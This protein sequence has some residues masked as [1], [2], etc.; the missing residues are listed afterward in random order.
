MTDI[1][2]FWD[3]A[4]R[5]DKELWLTGSNLYYVWTP[6][7]IM[8]KLTPDVKVLNIGVGFGKDTRE[9]A[10]VSTTVD[11]LDISQIALDRVKT[12]TRN[13]Y[14]SSNIETLPESEYD[15]AVSHLVTQHMDDY[16][17]LKQ[18]KYVIRS[19]KPDGI[20]SMQFAFIDETPE[21]IIQLNNVYKNVLD[22]PKNK[23]GHMFRSL[24]TMEDMVMESG[25]NIT[26]ISEPRKFPNIP[27][28]WYYIHIQK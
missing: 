9:I 26:W 14:L 22:I 1:K 27:I 6:M 28:K 18:L 17:L 8:N 19:L 10:K 7:N 11:V 15:L 16:D 13:Q 23:K 25:G 24:L 5:E 21:S 4:H 2:D 20:F 12:V 3:D